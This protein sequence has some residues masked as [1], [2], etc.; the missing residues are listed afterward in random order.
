MSRANTPELLDIITC[1]SG[2][3]TQRCPEF[4]SVMPGT[5]KG[6]AADASDNA[7][8]SPSNLFPHSSASRPGY[9][10]AN[11]TSAVSR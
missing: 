5:F 4:F 11:H 1:S 2:S 10:T 8:T 6:V 9:G 3:T 7:R